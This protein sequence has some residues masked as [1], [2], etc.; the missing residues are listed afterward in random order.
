MG[1]AIRAVRNGNVGMGDNVVIIGC[2]TIGLMMLQTAG[3]AGAENIIAVSRS[4]RKMALA[5]EL[6]AN[7]FVDSG[8]K[9]KA[10]AEIYALTKGRGADVVIDAAGFADTYDLA[11]GCCRK[12]GK[13][14]A[15]GYNGTSLEF[16][17]TNLIFKEIQLIGT[18]GFAEEGFMALEYLSKGK[19]KADKIITGRFPLEKT[20][21]AFEAVY[22]CDEIKV[23]IKPNE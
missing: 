16:P 6:G 9:E 20:Q 2:G 8:K 17:I 7:Y 23:I 18:T 11:V 13:V 19:I 12:G 21:D 22:S 15:L 10:V 5:L 14:I 3:I 1:N 4:D